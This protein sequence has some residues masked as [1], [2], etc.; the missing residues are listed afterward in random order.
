MYWSWGTTHPGPPLICSIKSLLQFVPNMSTQ[1]LRT[2]S[3]TLFIT[4]SHVFTMHPGHFLSYSMNFL[5]FGKFLFYYSPPP[6]PPNFAAFQSKEKRQDPSSFRGSERSFIPGLKAPQC[7]KQRHLCLW[8][9]EN[10]FLMF[11]NKTNNKMLHQMV[12]TTKWC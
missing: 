8:M 10:N 5:V 2:L 4:Y 7:Y 9:M 11:K 3:R 1:H 12:Q 6:P